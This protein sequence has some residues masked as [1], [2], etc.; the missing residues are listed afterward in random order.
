MK[1]SVVIPVFNE[2][3]YIGKCLQ[4]LNSQIEKPDEIIIVDNNC[5]DKTV[6][7]C[8]A[9]PVKI[10]KEEIQGITPARN[11]G[12]NEAKGDIIARTDADTMLPKDWILK[13]KKDFTNK[14]ID[15]L[16]G[17]LLF[18][19]LPIKSSIYTKV[20]MATMRTLNRYN[21]LNGP[22]LAISKKMWEKVRDHVCIK[23]SKVAEDIDLAVHIKKAGGVIYYDSSLTVSSSS[24]RIKKKPAS[25]F[26]N[27]PIKTINTLL[28]H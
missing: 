8:K 28:S 13:I 12:F 7:I 25:F 15:A 23:D 2:E 5:S 9:F 6:E 14:K 17:P 4:S 27:Y 22:N 21:I 24:R 18:Y 3:K 11:R 26:I 1:V 16:T 20:Y 10:V 19:D